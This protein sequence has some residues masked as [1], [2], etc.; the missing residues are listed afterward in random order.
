MKQNAGRRSV[1]AAA[2]EAAVHKVNKV[3]GPNGRVLQ[4]RRLHGHP[5]VLHELV[6][7]ELDIRRLLLGH[8]DARDAERPDVRLAVARQ[9]VAEQRLCAEYLGR[10]PVSAL[11]V[12]RLAH[13]AAAQTNVGRRHVEVG[14]LYGVDVLADEQVACAQV[15]VEDVELLVQEVEALEH[16]EAHVVYLHLVERRVEVIDEP[17]YRS[18]R[19]VLGEEPESR[20][21][22]VGVVELD[23][24]LVIALANDVDLGHDLVVARLVVQRAHHLADGEQ[25][26]VLLHE[27]LLAHLLLVVVLLVQVVVDVPLLLPH[28]HRVNVCGQLGQLDEAERLLLEAR[29]D[30]RRR[31]AG[32]R[33]AAAHAVRHDVALAH[34]GANCTRQ[35]ARV[36]DVRQRVLLAEY[37]REAVGL[38]DSVFGGKRNGAIPLEVVGLRAEHFYAC[39]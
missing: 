35:V 18:M 1:L 16:V 12:G 3:L 5:E 11:H 30:A 36:V 32:E 33:A 20:V 8:L 15:T 34:A 29:V 14:Q 7:R 24:V 9:V 39:Y 23:D 27:D 28:N 10:H 21:E 25:V 6:A 4:R 22:V 19:A 17:F 38:L 2:E 37:G 31:A 13:A 26:V